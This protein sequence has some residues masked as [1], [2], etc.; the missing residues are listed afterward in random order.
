ADRRPERPLPA[1]VPA[2][3]RRGRLLRRG[4]APA[5][6][7]ARGIARGRAAERRARPGRGRRAEGGGAA[8]HRGRT[9][10]AFREVRRDAVA[11]CPAT[12]A[13]PPVRALL[14]E[15]SLPDRRILPRAV[16]T[17]AKQPAQS[18]RPHNPVRANLHMRYSLPAVAAL[19]A[20]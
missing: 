8:S 10:V 1:H 4:A 20:L 7:P 14:D 12:H 2:P 5:P 13:S 11:R 6:D 17:S 3:P 18:R 9:A 19:A 15:Q 16:V